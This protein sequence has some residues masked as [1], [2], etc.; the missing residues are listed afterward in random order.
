MYNANSAHEKA[1]LLQNVNIFLPEKTVNF[2]SDDQPWA[3]SEIKEISRRK[4]EGI[5]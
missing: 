5:L 2:T 4:K 1:E 3:T